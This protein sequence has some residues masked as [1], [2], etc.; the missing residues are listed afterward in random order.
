MNNLYKVRDQSRFY[1][2]FQ[3]FWKKCFFVYNFL[4]NYIIG[5]LEEHNI[6][7]D[8]QFGFRKSHAIITLVEKVSKALDTGRFVVG[9]FLD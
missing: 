5:F 9:I 8:R 2:S 1:R 6:L 7:Y 3:N 4:I